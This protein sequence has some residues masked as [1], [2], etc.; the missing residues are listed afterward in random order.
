MKV[1]KNLILQEL[2]EIKPA[3]L[4]RGISK[5]ALFGSYAKNCQNVYSD[6]DIAIKKDRNFLQKFSAYD[7][8]ETIEF[9]K[10]TLSKKLKRKIDILDLDSKSSTAKKV[11]KEAIYV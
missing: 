3:V 10:K 6:I 4:K 1:D 9:I 7:Y 8:F 5:L 11:K 2:K